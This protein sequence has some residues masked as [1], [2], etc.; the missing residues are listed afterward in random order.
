MEAE[1]VEIK[2]G[3]PKWR[4]GKKKEWDEYCML[5]K[6][7]LKDWMEE[8]KRGRVEDILVQGYIELVRIMTETAEKTIGRR[9]KGERKGKINRKLARAIVG[10]NQAKGAWRREIAKKGGN[11]EVCRIR[12]MTKAQTVGQIMTRMQTISRLQWQTQVMREGG[13]GSK[14]Y[15]MGYQ[16]REEA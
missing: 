3:K 7:R 2:G 5:L 10:R 1:K 13:C 6:G 15:G 4:K 11:I 9:K 8:M 12:M 16:R 14:H